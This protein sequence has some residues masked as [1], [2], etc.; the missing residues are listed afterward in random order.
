MRYHCD[1]T[2]RGNL[3]GDQPALVVDIRH[4]FIGVQIDDYTTVATALK[5]PL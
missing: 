1:V 2:A 3:S 4:R 5:C